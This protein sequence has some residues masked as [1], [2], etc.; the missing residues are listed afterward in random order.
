[1]LS[2]RLENRSLMTRA[3]KSTYLLIYNK[4]NKSF[5][6]FIAGVFSRWK[7]LGKSHIL[8]TNLFMQPRQ[9]I[10][11]S[12]VHPSRIRCRSSIIDS[13]TD[14]EQTRTALKRDNLLIEESAATDILVV[15]G[16]SY[17][18]FDRLSTR[19]RRPTL[20]TYNCNYML[21]VES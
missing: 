3:G 10:R 16:I 9:T 8:V 17:H 13:T 6:I 5:L 21:P 12:R 15:I 7:I 1:M 14:V 20:H 18:T 2:V 4:Q 19:S 11:N